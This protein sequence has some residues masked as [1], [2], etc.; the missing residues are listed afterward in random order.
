MKTGI[1]TVFYYF[2]FNLQQTFDS[3]TNLN[4]FIDQIQLR[5]QS[6]FQI[7]VDYDK[8]RSSDPQLRSPYRSPSQQYRSFTKLSYF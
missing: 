8:P 5:Q 2:E 3:L 4:N 6:W 1:N 7:Y